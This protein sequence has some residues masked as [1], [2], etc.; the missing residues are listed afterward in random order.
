MADGHDA[1]EQTPQLASSEADGWLSH[2][3][4]QHDATETM[5][6]S[7]VSKEEQALSISS[8][9]ERLSYNEYTTIDWLH[10]VVSFRRTLS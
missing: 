9:G 10:D 1:D 7:Y 6:Q 8:V 5:I 3:H 2:L 4:H